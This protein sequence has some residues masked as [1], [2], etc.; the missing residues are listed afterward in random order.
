MT[1]VMLVVNPASG[2]EES[3]DYASEL[4]KILMKRE[5]DI[6]IK[7]TKE[8]GD[9]ER[10]AE[11]ASLEGYDELYLFGGDGTIRE[12]LSGVAEK[13]HRPIL[14]II[15]TGT[16]NNFARMVGMPM[17]PMEA[18]QALENPNIIDS[19]IGTVNNTY[20]VSALSTGELPESARQ[21]D[22]EKK[23]VLGPLA[24]AVEGLKAL[25]EEDLSRFQIMLDG[26]RIEEDFS[27]VLIANGNSVVGI[28]SFFPDASLTDGKLNFFGLKET[29][30]IEKISV[31]PELFKEDKDNSEHIITESFEK[32]TITLE[33]GENMG[34]ATD[35]DEGP[36]FP[37]DISILK[38]HLKVFTPSGT[39]E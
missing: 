39:E 19:D 23:T 15:P 22:D 16:V 11:E 25:R 18:V 17:D 37:L 4:T 13:N 30:I 9:A 12:G 6:H 27:L 3:P 36:G 14:G 26:K 20:F 1:Q 32:A 10:F 38:N 7:T 5:A 24:Y 21:V 8:I 35:G 31:V 33:K 34:T 29:S 2:V 28:E